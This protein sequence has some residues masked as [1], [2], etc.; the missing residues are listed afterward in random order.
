M[1]QSSG[2]TPEIN[3]RILPNSFEFDFFNGMKRDAY[4]EEVRYA[5]PQLPIPYNAPLNNIDRTLLS[6]SLINRSGYQIYK[7]IPFEENKSR[8]LFSYENGRNLDVIKTV[9][10]NA[11]RDYPDVITP[12]R[13]VI[14]RI[15]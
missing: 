2:G 15:R 14:G 4:Y 7:Q 10:Y 13:Q 9:N 12:Q 1:A 6:S 11:R 5:K 8:P 3:S